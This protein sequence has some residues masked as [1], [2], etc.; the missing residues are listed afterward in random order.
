[1]DGLF[2]LIGSNCFRLNS[3]LR[4]PLIPPRSFNR[5]DRLLRNNLKCT[6]I[7]S[8]I[9]FEVEQFE[10]I[11]RPTIDAD[12]YLVAEFAFAQHH[13]CLPKFECSILM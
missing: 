11:V 4:I 2:L 6:K 13:H 3:S 10:T 7:H 9:T 1:M 8:K 12:Q 5:S